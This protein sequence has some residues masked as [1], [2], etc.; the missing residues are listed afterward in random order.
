MHNNNP[1]FLENSK[2]L[3]GV[4]SSQGTAHQVAGQ[5]LITLIKPARK[6]R[7]GCLRYN[8]EGNHPSVRY[9]YD[10]GEEYTT[11]IMLGSPGW[12]EHAPTGG[13]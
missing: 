6:V 5:V 2:I 1:P 4:D 11:N 7:F 13:R 12:I 10:T 8:M 9:R 3:F